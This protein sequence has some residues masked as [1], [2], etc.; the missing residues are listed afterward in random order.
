MQE[1]RSL[2]LFTEDTEIVKG[3]GQMGCLKVWQ[4]LELAISLLNRHAEHKVKIH[5]AKEQN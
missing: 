1:S 3:T 2:V 5:L 4:L